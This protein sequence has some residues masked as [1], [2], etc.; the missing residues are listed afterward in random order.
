MYLMEGTGAGRFK[1]ARNMSELF[2]NFAKTSH[3]AAKCAPEW[4]VDTTGKRATMQIDAECKVVND[5]FA[6]ERA[7]WQNLGS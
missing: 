3:P 5:P 6:Q 1:V 7:K 2:T 4:P